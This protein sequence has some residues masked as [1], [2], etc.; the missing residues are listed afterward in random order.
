MISALKMAEVGLE[1]LPQLAT[2]W[3]AIYVAVLW[4]SSAG[5]PLLQYISIITSTFTTVLTIMSQI[6]LSREE[7]FI[8][9][10]FSVWASYVP[11][12]LFILAGVTA[13]TTQL[14]FFGVNMSLDTL[15]GI[16]VCILYFPL[17]AAAMFFDLLIVII[18]CHNLCWRIWCTIIHFIFTGTAIGCIFFTLA[19]EYEQLFHSNNTNSINSLNAIHIFRFNLLCTVLHLLLGLLVLPSKEVGSRLFSP[20]VN[21]FIC[22][23]RKLSSAKCLVKWHDDITDILDKA[24]HGRIGGGGEVED[25]EAGGD[26]VERGEEDGIFSVFGRQFGNILASHA[27][28][29]SD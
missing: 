10:Q 19:T 7:Q 16:Y 21:L 28:S 27:S 15:S 18:P 5:Y 6:L 17:N 12:C 14:R 25:R 3:A 13:G 23:L 4:S 26:E 20:L 2:Q 1:S 24:E 29:M 9:A 11:L 22:C 8:S